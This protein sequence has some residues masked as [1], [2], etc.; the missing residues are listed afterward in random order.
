[1]KIKGRTVLVTGANRGIGKALTEGF[2]EHGA[3]KVYA[4]VR[5]PSSAADLLDKHAGRVTSVTLD[6]TNSA[7]VDEAARVATDV[8]IVVNNAGVLRLVDPLDPSVFDALAFELNV[9]LLGLLRIAQAFAP[10][11]KE[12]GGGALVQLNSIAS[13]QA[14]SAAASYSASKA[15]AYSMTQALREALV[16]QGTHVVSV[17]PGPITSGMAQ[18]AGLAEIAE[19]PELVVEEVIAALSEERFHS[20]PGTMAQEYAHAYS[21]FAKGILGD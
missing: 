17:H 5:D 14:S 21:S 3:K 9:N 15:A 6:I 2:L 20:F 4:G 13:L 11:L 1:V 18:N 19:P 10:I 12:N 8:E 16:D 7:A